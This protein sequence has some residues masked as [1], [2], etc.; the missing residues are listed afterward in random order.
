MPNDAVLP[1]GRV[2]RRY[3][4]FL[5]GLV[6]F[7][8]VAVI[9]VQQ[10]ASVFTN[11]LWYRS[12]GADPVWRVMTITRL[13]LDVF[14][15]GIF[16]VLCWISL[17][18]VDRV[19]R[20]AL[21]MSP[22][23]E[24]IRRYQTIIAGHKFA[25]RTVVSFLLALAVGSGAPSQ[26]QNWLLFLHGGNFGIRDPQFHRDVGFYVFRLPFLSFLVGWTQ[27]ALI[28]L[29]IVCVVAYYLNG[30]VRFSG[31]S[32]RVDPRATAHLSVILAAM[33]LLRAA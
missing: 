26:W 33:A 15:A 31:P 3:Q 14:F 27:V 16:F 25:L 11:Y 10:A 29:F 32:P 6:V 13:E 2:I 21:F 30:G 1:S 28:V 18:M 19:A 23:Q 7:V 9:V 4:V 8:I 22:E 17:F 12:E 5:L 24:L 20:R